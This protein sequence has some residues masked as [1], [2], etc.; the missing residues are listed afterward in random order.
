MIYNVS[1]SYA[2]TARGEKMSEVTV[3]RDLNAAKRD[4]TVFVWSIAECKGNSRG[5]TLERVKELNL[6]RVR[7]GFSE[8]KYRTTQEGTNPKRAVYIWLI[9]EIVEEPIKGTLQ[10]FSCNPKRGES[11]FRFG[12]GSLVD[13]NKVKG[14]RL[15]TTGAYA[16]GN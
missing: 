14:V 8:Y 7:V 11:A 2:T 1:F 12:D 4:M 10:R 5:K 13:F 15:T 9:G 16:I 6:T 3:I